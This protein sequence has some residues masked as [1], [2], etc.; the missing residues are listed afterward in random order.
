MISNCVSFV[1][2]MFSKFVHL[3]YAIMTLLEIDFL[4]DASSFGVMLNKILLRA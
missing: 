3:L 2:R 1:K 4:K